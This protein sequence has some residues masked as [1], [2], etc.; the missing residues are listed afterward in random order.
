LDNETQKQNKTGYIS[1]LLAYLGWGFFPIYWKFLIHVPLMQ[2]LA[3][4]LL[5]SF[6]FYSALLFLRNK[7][8]SLFLPKGYKPKLMLALAS[9]LLMSNWLVYIYAVNSNQV[10]ESS[11]G[12]F[13]NPL[14]NILIGVLVLKERLT[15]IQSLATLLA[16]I[17]VIVISLDQSRLPYLALFLAITFSCYG[18]IKKQLALPGIESNQ[19]ETFFFIPMTLI[20]LYFQDYTWFRTDTHPLQSLALLIGAGLVTGIPLIFFTEAARRLPYYVLGFF[21]FLSPSIQFLTGVFLYNEYLSQTKLFGFIF[22]WAACFVMLLDTSFKAYKNF[23]SL[24]K[25]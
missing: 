23:Y 6:V 13:I 22:I 12:Y 19:F 8:W 11:L 9:I 1:A 5:W 3:H 2:I 24:S 18:F 21:Q 10:V 16:F 17:G 20:F 7:K 14:V 25:T 15:K 4:R